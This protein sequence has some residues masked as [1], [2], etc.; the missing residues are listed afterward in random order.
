MNQIIVVVVVQNHF[1]VRVIKIINMEKNHIHQDLEVNF[2]IVVVIHLIRMLV[3]VL[4]LIEV[5]Q[6]I[7]KIAMKLFIIKKEKN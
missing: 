4:V 3:I 5:I 1:Q 7:R 6:I 2:L